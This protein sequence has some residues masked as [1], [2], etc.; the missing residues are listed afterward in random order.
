MTPDL[1]NQQRLA[2]RKAL[3]GARKTMPPAVRAQA[4]ATL[5]QQLRAA[6]DSIAGGVLA[7]YWPIQAEFDPRPA[8]TAWLAGN[9]ARQA[10][11]PVVMGKQQPLQ[12]RAWSSAT[13]MQPAGFGTSVPSTGE[14]LVPTVLLIP[15]VG[16]DDQGYRLG[17]GGGF[18]DRTLAALMS[19]PRTIGIGYAAGRLDSIHPQP[20][21]F[22][23][24]ALLTG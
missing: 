12:F 13:V 1:L 6:L 10:A 17:Y 18:Y 4:D 8:I 16:F 2:W 11:L 22:K 14:W 20:H 19:R 24:D 23:L 9:S 7:F 3:L 5:D 21:D 15:L